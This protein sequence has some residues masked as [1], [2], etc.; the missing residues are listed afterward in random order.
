[1][2]MANQAGQMVSCPHCKNNFHLPGH[3]SGGYQ[4]PYQSPTSSPFGQGYVSDPVR[5]FAGKKIAAGICG[6]LLGG[7]GV[8]KF[9]LGFNTAGTIMLVTYLV[10]LI[11]GMCL[12]VPIFATMAVSIIGLIEGILYLTKS[13]EEFYYVYGVQ[14]KEW[15]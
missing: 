7:L 12:V 1:M 13:D 3:Q 9:I 11:T 5:E 6:I 4:N 14:R 2:M 8:H 10:G 15:F